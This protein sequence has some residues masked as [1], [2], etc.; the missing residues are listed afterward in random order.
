MCIVGTKDGVLAVH[1]FSAHK[2]IKFDAKTI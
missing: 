1:D 2:P